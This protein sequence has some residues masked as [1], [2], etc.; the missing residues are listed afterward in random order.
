MFSEL[1]YCEKNTDTCKNNGK[2]QSLEADDGNFRCE[3]PSGISGKYCET[4]P[5][6]TTVAIAN[7]TTTEGTTITVTEEDNDMSSEDVIEKT[8]EMTVKKSDKNVNNTSAIAKRKRIGSSPVLSKT[9]Q[10]TLSVYLGK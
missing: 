7:I 3:C 4:L 10:F 8:T 9:K 1:N 2:C 6:A 5:E